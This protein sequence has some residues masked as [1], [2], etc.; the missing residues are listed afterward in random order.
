[1][2]EDWANTVALVALGLGLGTSAT[3][4]QLLA[5]A[6]LRDSTRSERAGESLF[7]AGRRSAEE[8][9]EVME[10]GPPA[11]RLAASA[12]LAFAIVLALTVWLSPIELEWLPLLLSIGA[13]I[14]LTWLAF[15]LGQSGR[16]RVDQP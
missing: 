6:A 15:R 12:Q 8:G 3:L 13:G 10:S 2:L 4:T 9:R 16:V 7:D 11:F 5:P 14:L 1:V